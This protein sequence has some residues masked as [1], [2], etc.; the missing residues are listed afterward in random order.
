MILTKEIKFSTKGH[1]DII[2]ITLQVKELI[3]QSH[4]RSGIITLF[5]PGTTAVITTMEYESGLIEDIKKHWE[6][7]VSSKE[8]YEH[9]ERWKDGNGYAHVRSALCGPSLVIPFDEGK[10]I[11]G[12]WQDVVFIDFDNRPRSRT[13]IAQI[14]G[15]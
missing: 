2:N 12:T 13:V 14:Q 11:L 8:S 5:V 15:E 9:N 7:M 10:L 3:E 1:T 6:N 4:I